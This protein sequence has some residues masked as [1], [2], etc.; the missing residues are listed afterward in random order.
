MEERVIWIY[1]I[2]CICGYEYEEVRY[3]HE[4]E[5]TH[6]KGDEPFKRIHLNFESEQVDN[7]K[8]IF[9]CPKCG[10]IKFDL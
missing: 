4:E 10:T 8:D 6:T 2:K 5:N 9:V 7:K 3:L 1:N